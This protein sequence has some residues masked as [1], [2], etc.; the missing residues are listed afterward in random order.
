MKKILLLFPYRF[1]EYEY[2]KYEIFKLEKKYNVKV[3]IHDLSNVVTNKKLNAVWKTKLEK[4]TLKFSSLISW[5]F[6]F[7]KIKKE[8]IIIFSHIQTSNLNS[9]IINFL[10][11]VSKLPIMFYDEASPFSKSKKNTYFF[12]SKIKEHGF[13]YRVYLFYLE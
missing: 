4:K 1:T 6:Y 11:K 13:N 7:N 5:I 12:L 2:Y 3:I 8:K 9:F 10:I